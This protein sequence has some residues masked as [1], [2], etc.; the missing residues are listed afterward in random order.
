VAHIR[1]AWRYD[2][3]GQAYGRIFDSHTEGAGRVVVQDSI[4]GAVLLQRTRPLW[5]F[6]NDNSEDNNGFVDSWA[7]GA[8]VF[9]NAGQLFTVTFL[10]TAM[11]ADSGTDYLM[12]WSLAAAWIEMQVLFVVVEL[13]P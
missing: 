2:W 8:D 11:V 9:V 10:A 4:S 1:P 7:L 3:Q 6:N 5:S 12:G 13:G